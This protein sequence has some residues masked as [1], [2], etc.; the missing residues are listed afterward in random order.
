LA[1]SGITDA[2]GQMMVLD[3]VLD[4]QIFDFDALVSIDELLRLF[5]MNIPPLS[6][7]SQMLSGQQ[8]NLS[9]A[10]SATRSRTFG[11]A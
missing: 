3:H 6:L 11:E 1:P 4:L 2:L 5:E 9:F 10:K 8:P 7:D